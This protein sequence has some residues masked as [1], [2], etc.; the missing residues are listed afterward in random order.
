MELNEGDPLSRTIHIDEPSR[1]N[2]VSELNTGDPLSKAIP[3]KPNGKNSILKL[4]E[5]DHLWR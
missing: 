4:N 5:G 3:C 1:R 2:L